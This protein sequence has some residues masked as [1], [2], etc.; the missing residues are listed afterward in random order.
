MDKRRNRPRKRYPVPVPIVGQQIRE[1]LYA[2]TSRHPAFKGM[3]PTGIR[4]YIEELLTVY[5]S[6]QPWWYGHTGG[7]GGADTRGHAATRQY[8]ARRPKGHA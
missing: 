1:R 7:R 8:E 6:K 3:E 2:E 5:L 4:K